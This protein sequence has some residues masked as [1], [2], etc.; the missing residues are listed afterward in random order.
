MFFLI[1]FI[2]HSQQ[3]EELLDTRG[4]VFSHDF[5]LFPH[6][7]YGT[8]HSYISGKWQWLILYLVYESSRQLS[9][10]QLFFR[11]ERKIVVFVLLK[12][13]IQT[14]AFMA[15]FCSAPI[16]WRRSWLSKS[17]VSKKS[18][19]SATECTI[20]MNCLGSGH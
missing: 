17:S 19:P 10:C 20:P 5:R 18:S 9:Y 14:W 13:K 15:Y 12:P 11:L 7:L 8:C 2:L 1:Y 6:H 4:S 3:M 16:I